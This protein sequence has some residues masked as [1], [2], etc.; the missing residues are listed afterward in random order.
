M[1]RNSQKYPRCNEINDY[2]HYH[3]YYANMMMGQ[4]LL[5]CAI[6]FLLQVFRVNEIGSLVAET[7]SSIPMTV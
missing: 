2:D 7:C 3:T 1:Y 5:L 6:A 4:A